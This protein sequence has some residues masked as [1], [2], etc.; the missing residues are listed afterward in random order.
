MDE[1]LRV[2]GARDLLVVWAW[3]YYEGSVF[4]PMPGSGLPC[5]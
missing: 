2:Y 4:F 1:K 5:L 3:L